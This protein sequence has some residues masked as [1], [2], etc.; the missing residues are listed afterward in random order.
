[1]FTTGR[2]AFA[3]LIEAAC[4]TAIQAMGL[5]HNAGYIRLDLLRFVSGSFF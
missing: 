1:M 2:M 3:W 5:L 4:A